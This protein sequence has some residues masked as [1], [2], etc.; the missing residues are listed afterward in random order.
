MVLSTR[1]RATRFTVYDS[2]LTIMSVTS[3]ISKGVEV[4]S[5]DYGHILLLDST[6]SLVLRGFSQCTVLAGRA[7]SSVILSSCHFV[8][9]H[10][11]VTSE[12]EL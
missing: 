5:L 12:R 4:E 3:M 11:V 10:V 9:T 7:T 1:N 2:S 6:L 8:V